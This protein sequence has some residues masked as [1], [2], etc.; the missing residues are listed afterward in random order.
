M[1]SDPMRL[2]QSAGRTLD[3]FPLGM[4]YA[5]AEVI[6]DSEQTEMMRVLDDVSSTA[7]G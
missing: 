3:S 7:A 5:R 6:G 1:S 4:Q 2:Y